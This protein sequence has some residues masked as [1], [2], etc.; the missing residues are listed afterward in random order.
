MQIDNYK[1]NI[2]L[3]YWAKDTIIT[4]YIIY[5]VIMISLRFIFANARIDKSAVLAIIQKVI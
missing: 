2:A 4:S 5:D 1:N 3:I